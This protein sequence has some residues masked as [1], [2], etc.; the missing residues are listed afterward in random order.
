MNWSAYERSAGRG[1]HMTT[2]IVRKN[3]YTFYERYNI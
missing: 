2:F 1:S 3:F